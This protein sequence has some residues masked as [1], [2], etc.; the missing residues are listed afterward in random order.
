MV[1][2]TMSA[3]LILVIQLLH[4]SDWREASTLGAKDRYIA[5]SESVQ[6]RRSAR[7]AADHST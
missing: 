2:A 7:L 5:A 6:V 3:V 1:L 4:Y